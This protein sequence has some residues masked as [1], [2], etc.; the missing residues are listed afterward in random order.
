MR[1]S[2]ASAIPA[3]MR[4]PHNRKRNPWEDPPERGAKTGTQRSSSQA[5]KRTMVQTRYRNGQVSEE[6]PQLNGRLHGVLRRWHKNGV[7]A[8]EQ[9]HQNGVVH[10]ICRQWNEDG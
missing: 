9:P 3:L 7:L 4:L 2:C 1:T 10:G 8:L 6:Q 5:T